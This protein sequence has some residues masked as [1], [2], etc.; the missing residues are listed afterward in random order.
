MTNKNHSFIQLIQT[1][2]VKL[3]KRVSLSV[4]VNLYG[5]IIGDNTKIGSFV[6][7]QKNAVIGDNCKISSHTFICSG[8]T[9]GNGCFIGH[10]VMFINDNYPHALNSRGELEKEVDWSK[11]FVKTIIEDNVSIGT[12]S[13]ILGNVKIGT[14]SL[15]GAGSVV[16]GNIPSNQVWA[17]NPAR[18][19]RIRGKGNK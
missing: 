8:V 1:Q 16:T 6:E 18:F 15:V 3:G 5:C 13:T 11:R 10:G 17:G 2:G 14:N 7:I 19:I 12:N 9:I 4:F